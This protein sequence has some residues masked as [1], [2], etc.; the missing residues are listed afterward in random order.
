MSN[1]NI[2]NLNQK[3]LLNALESFPANSIYSMSPK[4]NLMQGFDYYKKNSLQGF[5]WDKE[6][7][8]L[9][10]QV[11]GYRHYA[12]KFSQPGNKLSLSCNCSEWT[13]QTQCKHVICAI[14]TIKNIFQPASFR[15]PSQ[16]MEHRN[17]MSASFF[18]TAA[19]SPEPDKPDEPAGYSIILEPGSS[20]TE[21]YVMNCN[22]RVHF[23]DRGIPRELKPLV[24]DRLYS[25]YYFK[26]YLRDYGNEYPIILKT[27][28][29]ETSVEFD[30]SLSYSCKTEI[31]TKKNYVTVRKV[32]LDKD[33]E[34]R[35]FFVENDLL[36]NLDDGKIGYLNETA[37]WSLWH[38][39]LDFNGYDDDFTVEMPK[40]SFRIPAG[41]FKKIQIVFPSQPEDKTLPDDLIIRAGGNEC[42]I[43]EATHTYRATVTRAKEESGFFVIKAECSLNGLIQSPSFNLFDFFSLIDYELSGSLR[44]NKR[45]E[46]LYKAFFGMISAK[47]KKAMIEA[48][49]N[50]LSEGDFKRGSVK[51]EARKFL[52]NYLSIF[53]RNEKQL[54][55]HDGNWIV[56]PVNKEK[57][58]ML[59]KIPYEIF[60][61]RIFKGMSEHDEMHIPS[62]SLHENLSL[63]YEKFREHNI[64]LFFDNKLVLESKWDFAFDARRRSGIDWFEIKPE[65]RCNGKLIDEAEWMEILG[66][67]K[68][69]EKDGAVQ[70]LDTNAQKIFNI[71]STIYK[72]GNLS[73]TGARGKEIVRVP[74]LQILDWIELRRSGVRVKLP[75]EDEEIIKRLSRFEKI[76]ARPLPSKLKA[77]LRQYQ[78]EGYYWLSFLYEH[79]FGS[80]L[81]DDMGLGKTIQ[82]ITLLAGIKEG[83]VKSPVKE[84]IC[85]HLIVVPPSL[86]FNW[87]NEINR[88]YPGLKIYLYTGKERD[89][90]FEGYDIVLTTY[91][92]VRRDIEKL[93]DIRFDVI[94]FDEAQAIKNIYA[95]TTGAV[96][97]L[98]ANFSMAVTGTPLENH[99]GEYYS[100][101][102]LVL[103]GLLGEYDKFKPLINQGASPALDMIIN[104][105]RPFVLRRTKEKI[106][107]EL[108]PKIENDIYLDLTEKQKALYK[109]TVEQVKS[110]IDDAYKSKTAAQ[111]KI[112]ALT[113]ILK[114][115]QLCVSP[116]LISGDIKEPSPKI[117]F[118]IAKLKEL[119]D[120][121]HSALVFSQFTSFLDILEKDLGKNRM[122]FLRLDG[123]TPVGKR[124]NLIE[125]FQSE[126][127]P[128]VFLLSLKAGGQGLNL[129]KAS[130][131]FHLDPWWNPAV[132][133][134]ASDRAHR[135]GQ[136]NKVTVTRILT[137]HTIEEKMMKLKKK[138]LALYK[139]VMDD[140]KGGKRSLS[141]SRS[142]FNFLLS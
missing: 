121:E 28:G 133:N 111:A 95:D 26:R 38:N 139:A 82:A 35:N 100:I 125:K 57:E 36:I 87:E 92:L 52:N 134:Q 13:P 41:R 48:I 103:P 71:I 74:R 131:V 96:R 5:K 128:A 79:R 27:G 90:A 109:K 6:F 108:P 61:W 53:L 77:R 40:E 56:S 81:A 76:D 80:C 22:K 50:A 116:A 43:T 12:V 49:R 72:S 78:K 99:V 104:R 68:L 1:D 25:L 98:S 118:L 142:D 11:Y 15:Y 55:V 7:S 123:S 17:S 102:D 21:A 62:K 8:S 69:M 138:K 10:A 105:T 70:V 20:G 32:C 91:G 117:D 86:L 97:R 89:T 39:L 106:L 67:K 140:T 14:I 34:I 60:G 2:I 122:D 113:A 107:K 29:K 110:R 135:I 132:E 64:K 112:I 33:R 73:K 83:L 30:G 54:Q 4:N 19:A 119:Q 137:H 9:T 58:A 63:L 24:S 127:G 66:K 47:T 37:G 44:A 124:K 59:Y 114:L 65:I 129:T 23:Y 136:K 130:Y 18:S 126:K 93:K 51:S 85:A 101:I 115:R 120:E 46:F 31:D 84:E 42:E 141:V 75:P 94:I 16:D 45:R 88:F 3:R